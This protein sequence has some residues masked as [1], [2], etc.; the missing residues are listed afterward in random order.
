MLYAF[1][2]TDIA[3]AGDK[4]R[5]LVASLRAK[6]PDAAYDAMDASTW[7]QSALEGHLGGQGLFS[8]KYIVLLDRLTE[9]AEAKEALP[10]LIPA[11]HESDNIFV[12]LEG[13]L[14]A[15]MKKALAAHA[16]KAVECEP[17]AA[18]SAGSS[19]AK[20]AASAKPEPNV[21]AIADA[22]GR[23]D[24]LRA[25]RLYREAIDA[26][27]S[28]EAIAGMLFWKAKALS[29]APLARELIV[30]YHDAH[31]GMLDLEIGLER[32]ILAQ[33]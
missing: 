17:K 19:A 22:F 32:C 31:R 7:N 4:A 26:G 24:A 16:D 13:K 25:W 6:R 20:G 28:P 21:F 10:D 2:G 8:S 27:S 18:A 30:L 5:A 23:H 15:D 29:S 33:A 9:N 14:L 3:Q 12:M 1:Y 11:L